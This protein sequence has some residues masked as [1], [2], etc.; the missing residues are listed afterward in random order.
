VTDNSYKLIETAWI[1]DGLDYTGGELRSHFVRET[2]GIKGDGIIA[3]QGG[4]NVAVDRLVDLEDRD[5]GSFIKAR[6]MLHF[7]CEHFH[8]P[9]REVNFRLRLFS[10]IVA[11]EI[12]GLAPDAAVI[13]S[14]DD[15]FAGG[16]KLSVAIATVSPVSSLFHFGINV[17]PGGAPVAAAGLSEL[18]V[19]VPGLAARVLDAYVQECSSVETALRKVRGVT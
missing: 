18:G 6:S 10:S 9:L 5:A 15:L 13:R 2:A 4:C 17:D 8:A 1:A 7:I 12:N 3:F 19:N 11:R 14:G 16:R